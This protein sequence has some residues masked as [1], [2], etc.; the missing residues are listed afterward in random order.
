MPTAG[1]SGSWATCPSMWPLTRRIPGPGRSCSSWTATAA[2][3]AWPA[4]RRTGF[5]ATGQLWG[6]PLYD[7]PVHQADG[8]RW[9][10]ARL[11]RCYQWYDVVRIDHF[12]GFDEYFCV[13]AGAPD[14]RQGSWRPGPGR[15]L[16][17]AMR[18]ALGD[19]PVIA[20][21][22]GYLTDSVRRL[23]A[24]CGF[25]GMKVLEFAFDSRDASSAEYLPYRYTP[26][27]VVYTGTH[28][29]ETVA[30]WYQSIRP[31]ERRAVC[32][33]LKPRPR[34]GGAAALGPAVRG[35][36]LGGQM[37]HPAHA[38]LPGPGQPRP[39]EPPLHA[40]RQLALARRRRR[41]DP[42]LAARLRAV[43]ETY[44][45]LPAGR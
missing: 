1:A 35:D 21:D 34:R 44:G 25:P 39:H 10:I 32:R 23:V 15:A 3:P 41:A 13:P 8:Y 36:G 28:D 7:W 17:D 37:V 27:C 18:A 40:G 9:W 22:L 20:E 14:A 5:S 30:G 42:R 12:R 4:C 19:R 26:N 45:R 33:Y 31:E 43:T 29:N 6:N 24:D 38:G 11:A 2:P 16:F